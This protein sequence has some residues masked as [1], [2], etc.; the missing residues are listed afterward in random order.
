VNANDDTRI[1]IVD[2]DPALLE[3]LPEALRLRLKELEIETCAS[4]HAAL[5]LIV[6]TDYDAIVT[7]IK[8]PGMDGLGLLDEI[9]KVRPETPTLL[10]TGHGEHDLAIQALRRGAYDYVQ[11]PID[12]D[13]FTASLERA[14]E[15]RNLARR[16]E[17]QRL[18]L[19]RHAHVLEHVGDGVFVVDR[20]GFVRFWNLAAEQ[21]T[22]ITFEQAVGRRAGEV[23]GDWELVAPSIPVAGTDR[24]KRPLARLLPF[25]FGG[26]ELWLSL[27]AVDIADATVYSFQD[28][29]DERVVDKLKDDFVATASHELRTPLAAIYGAAKTLDRTDILDE[30]GMQSL[31]A[32]ISAESERLARVIDDILFASHLDSHRLRLTPTPVAVIELA[33]EVAESMRAQYGDAVTLTVEAQP[34]PLPLVSVDPL[35][36]RRVLINLLDNAIKYSPE[37]G[38]VVLAVEADDRRLRLHVRDEGLGIPPGEQ[39]RI[40]E[41]FYRADPHLAR[42]VGG[43]GLGLYI[44]RELVQRMGGE[45]EVQSAAGKGSTFTVELPL[46]GVREAPD[47]PVGAGFP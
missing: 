40:F 29:T 9:Q 8:M 13:Y 45:I 37:G 26:R 30:E 42:G 21:I 7:D 23:M 19:E 5:G 44:C 20:D 47:A 28:R 38:T 25:E 46:P 36:L 16:I 12:R 31:I 14:I 43:T 10:I 4:A 15:R 24:P 39:E 33:A 3:A 34:G 2:D 6:D 41:K 11:K 18:E 32:I 27:L 1:L 17:Y 35:K 22:G